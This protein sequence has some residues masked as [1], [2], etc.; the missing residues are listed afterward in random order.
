MSWYIIVFEN[1]CSKMWICRIW[2]F[3]QLMGLSYDFCGIKY[4]YSLFGKKEE[5]EEEEEKLQFIKA[6]LF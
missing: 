6:S 5:E 3:L 1:W 2:L 4:I